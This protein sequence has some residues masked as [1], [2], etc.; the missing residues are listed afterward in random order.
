MIAGV[1]SAATVL[2]G[3]VAADAWLSADGD[4][5]LALLPVGAALGL[6]VAI[7]G[8]WI[9]HRQSAI[10]GRVLRVHIARA[11]GLV[12]RHAAGTFPLRRFEVNG[13]LPEFDRSHL[14]DLVYGEVS[15][16]PM[17]FCDA[18][19]DTRIQKAHLP[20]FRGPLV[21]SRFPKHAR[22]RTL[23][24]PDGGPVGNF[25]WGLGE[26]HRQRVK[27][28]SPDF[29]R[30]FAVYST[31]QVEARYLLTPTAMERL[32]ALYRRF[33]GRMTVAFSG[34]EF[35]LTLDDRRDWFPNPGLF[36][37]LTDPALIREQAEEIARLADIV[38]ILKLNMDCRV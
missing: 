22:G 29:E 14:E 10:A 25:F 37:D 20:V 12:Y 31:D 21:L 27:M 8:G 9:A 18:R 2:A 13:M 7:L 5:F 4:L 15:G 16:V 23:V 30:A 28:E 11:L 34:H 1:L 36:R 17:V 3:A 38:E 24:V 19:L 35:M 32:L 6:I 26:E 33:P